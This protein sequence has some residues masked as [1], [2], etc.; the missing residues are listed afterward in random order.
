M[1]RD[2]DFYVQTG[3]MFDGY[4]WA[5]RLVVMESGASRLDLYGPSSRSGKVQVV[6]AGK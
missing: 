2:T 3:Y 6:Q 4:V 5:P 1:S